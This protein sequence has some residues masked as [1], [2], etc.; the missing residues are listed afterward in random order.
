MKILAS[1]KTSFDELN[2]S[3]ENLQ[4]GL[5]E[6]LGTIVADR[7][8]VENDGSDVVKY[9][10]WCSM[11]LV[12]EDGGRDLTQ[13]PCGNVLYEYFYNFSVRLYRL[14][15][16][17]VTVQFEWKLSDDS[18]AKSRIYE[19]GNNLYFRQIGLIFRPSG[20]ADHD[21]EVPDM[22]EQPLPF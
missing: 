20:T 16:F 13:L 3:R 18:L 4:T 21:I 7:M 17:P 11:E 10:I 2:A 6:R 22:V 14:Q 9:D 19:A 1:K 8:Y 15:I 5:Q 12:K